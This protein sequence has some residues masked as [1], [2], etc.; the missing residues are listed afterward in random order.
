MSAKRP[1]YLTNY[2][3]V[4]GDD[5][6]IP[7]PTGLP[8]SDFPHGGENTLLLAEVTHESV[9]WMEPRDLEFDSMS[10]Q[11]NDRSRPSISSVHPKGPGIVC[12]RSITCW[13]WNPNASPDVVRALIVRQD[14]G[15]VTVEKLVEQGWLRR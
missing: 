4:V 12:A 2:V 13:R 8:V 9:H 7:G 14:G 5:T 11:I 3:V 6:A 15:E 10:F 1:R